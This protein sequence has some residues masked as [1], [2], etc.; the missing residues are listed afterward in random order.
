M[1][2]KRFG[3]TVILAFVLGVT[4]FGRAQGSDCDISILALDTNTH[5]T[6]I[7]GALTGTTYTEVSPSDFASADLSAYDVLYVASTFQDGAVTIPSQAALDALNSRADDIAAF[8][9]TGGG[10]VALS[11]PIGAGRYSWLPVSVI[12]PDGYNWGYNDVVIADP[13]HPVMQGLTSVGLSSWR[14]SGHTVFTDIGPLHSVAA[15]SSGLPVTLVGSFGSGRIVLS[16]QDAAWHFDRNPY[17]GKQ[18]VEFLQNAINWAAG[19]CVQ[20]VEID[21]KPGSYPNSIN[22]NAGGVIPVA[23]L[24]TA[25]FDASAV[26]PA[27]VALEGAGTRGKGKS[28]N[29][30][31][32]EDV[33]GDGDLDLVVHVMNA[34]EWAANATEA[35]LTGM[36][37]DGIPI[38][39]TDSVRIVPPE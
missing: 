15:R 16:G 31:S 7:L 19:P 38:E 21:I 33:D 14:S 27:T 29:Y 28:G 20:V 37:W 8:A 10:I 18:Y 24:T 3:L 39:G 36:T 35:T 32:T 5:D 22:P 30:G 6:Q 34:I 26:D 25:D 13:I 17:V 2:T 11:E 23:I 4:G 12:A 1:G 9:D